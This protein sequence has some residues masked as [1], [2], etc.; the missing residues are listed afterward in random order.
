MDDLYE[1]QTI[2][3]EVRGR[4]VQ[5]RLAASGKVL[6]IYS[7]V[8]WFYWK[9]TMYA[10]LQQRVRLDA[11]GVFATALTRTDLPGAKHYYIAQIGPRSWK[12][13]MDGE[14]PHNLADLISCKKT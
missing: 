12:F 11:N 14:G 1:T 9:G 13:S 5:G 10:C 4:I 7:S 8:P 6:W 2:T 3:A